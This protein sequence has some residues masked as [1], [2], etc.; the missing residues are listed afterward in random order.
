M[1]NVSRARMFAL[2]VCVMMF[3][4]D[5]VTHSAY[6]DEED[7]IASQN[8]HGR[9]NVDDDSN[10]NI[11]HQR[12]AAL[13][14]TVFE[15]KI[16]IR[17]HI[18]KV[19]HESQPNTPNGT[20]PKK[21]AKSQAASDQT[22]NYSVDTNYFETPSFKTALRFKAVNLSMCNAE[23]EWLQQSLEE[24][25]KLENQPELMNNVIMDDLVNKGGTFATYAHQMRCKFNNSFFSKFL[26]KGSLG[27]KKEESLLLLNQI[28]AAY[29]RILNDCFNK[30]RNMRNH[31]CE[32][33]S[34]DSSAAEQSSAF[35]TDI[36]HHLVAGTIE[37][38]RDT[39]EYYQ[40]LI[41]KLF[42]WRE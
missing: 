26:F 31:I 10:I 16:K 19:K 36:K 25:K 28:D 21:S 13:D 18:N 34:I 35:W 9:D 2:L 40:N 38:P 3:M 23:Y 4:G 17:D 29:T 15:L 11:L 20:C 5:H 6:R 32:A 37:D 24:V 41:K 14:S 33:L 1:N 27:K 39:T 42:A 30:K 12:V 22:E 8:N 7:H